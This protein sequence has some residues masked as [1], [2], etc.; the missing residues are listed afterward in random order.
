MTSQNLQ[1]CRLACTV[2]AEEAEDLPALWRPVHEQYTWR[3]RRKPV[4]STMGRRMSSM[5]SGRPVPSDCASAGRLYESVVAAIAADWRRARGA[6]VLGFSAD[7]TSALFFEATRAMLGACA[8]A[9]AV[10]P[11][12]KA[13]MRMRFMLVVEEERKMF[14]STDGEMWAP[15]QSA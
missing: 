3:T 10:A 8:G 1:A 11:A 5:P 4:A 14:T 12:R 15:S 13:R 6:C 2:L 9:K 7:I